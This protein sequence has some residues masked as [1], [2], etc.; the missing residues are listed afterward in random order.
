MDLNRSAAKP[1]SADGCRSAPLGRAQH[2]CARRAHLEPFC[3]GRSGNAGTQAQQFPVQLRYRRAGRCPGLDLEIGELTG[4]VVA[5]CCG[6]ARHY[7]CRGRIARSGSLPRRGRTPL[8]PHRRRQGVALPVTQVLGF[9]GV[10]PS[11]IV[12]SACRVASDT[13]LSS[14]G[15]PADRSPAGA[16]LT[17]NLCSGSLPDDAEHRLARRDGGLQRRFFSIAFRYCLTGWSRRA[18]LVGASRSAVAPLTRSPRALS[19]GIELRMRPVESM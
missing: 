15:A 2:R 4:D 9:A 13:G 6:G 16:L 17:R 19:R 12:R 8:P 5:Q 10:H 7:A 18:S 11:S 14:D 1:G 3:R